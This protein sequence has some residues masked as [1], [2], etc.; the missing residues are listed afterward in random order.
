MEAA[1][2]KQHAHPKPVFHCLYGYYN[3]GYS[4]QELADVYDKTV[5]TIGNWMKVY[6]NTGTFQRSKMSFHKKFIA[7]QRQWLYDYYQVKPLSY[8]DAAQA[9][10][11]QNHRVAISQTPVW[12]IIHDFGLTWKV[13][14]RRA[15]HVKERDVFRFVEEL[16]Q[17]NWSHQ[18]L[19]ILDKVSFDNRGMIRKRGYAMRGEKVAVRGDFQRKSRISILA[20]IGVN[21]VLNYYGKQGTFDRVSFVECCRD[22]VYSDGGN[23]R[24]YP[25]VELGVDP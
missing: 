9:T 22:F 17:V 10:F 18:N 7:A 2:T 20:F 14:E 25:G 6:E 23:V 15:M 13:L 8:L 19:V 12:R 5:R 24:Q 3:L 11:T 21:G 1:E 4:R 16:S